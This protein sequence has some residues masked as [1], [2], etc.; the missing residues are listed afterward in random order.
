VYR[1]AKIPG[2]KRKGENLSKRKLGIPKC[3]VKV[4]GVRVKSTLT[5]KKGNGNQAEAES[6]KF[7]H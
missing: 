3:T 2:T 5:K 7:V 1:K 6:S 4:G